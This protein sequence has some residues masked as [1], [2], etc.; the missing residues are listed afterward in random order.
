MNTN[1]NSRNGYI[2]LY[3]PKTEGLGG[4]DVHYINAKEKYESIKRS[5]KQ[6][7]NERLAA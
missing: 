2:H 7:N 5:I 4:Y 6:K 3:N 1:L